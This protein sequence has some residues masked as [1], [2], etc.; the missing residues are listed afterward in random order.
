MAIIRFWELIL[1][2]R[3]HT[4]GE[5]PVLG[6][7]YK[8]QRTHRVYTSFSATTVTASTVAMNNT[9]TP[10][11]STHGTRRGCSLGWQNEGRRLSP[12]ASKFIKHTRTVHAQTDLAFVV[13]RRFE[14]NTL[15]YLKHVIGAVEKTHAR[16]H[17]ARVYIVHDEKQV[18][19]ECC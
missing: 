5:K 17:T 3:A 7:S 13:G 15:R 2:I 14:G 16:T 6:E 9:T 12:Y 18:P 19:G 8:K 1:K 4:Y 10:S 11:D